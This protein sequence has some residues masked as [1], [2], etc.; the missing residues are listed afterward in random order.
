MKDIR[1]VVDTNIF[2]SCLLKSPTNRLIYEAFKEDK[3]QLVISER[4][5]EEIKEVFLE[6]ELKIEPALFQELMAV[7]KLRAIMTKPPSKD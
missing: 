7:I 2:V 4:L 1:A 5:L 6:K 3:F